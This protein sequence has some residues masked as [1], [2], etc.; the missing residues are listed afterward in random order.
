[1]SKIDDLMDELKQKR[2]EL[3]LKAHLG[4]KEAQQEWS[5]LEKKWDDLVTKSGL[6]QTA[7]N[8]GD[9]LKLLGGELKEGY[10]RLKKA[11]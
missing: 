6:D 11:L 1:M 3:K 7:E 8:V 2:D 5:E 4:S 10:T 9:A